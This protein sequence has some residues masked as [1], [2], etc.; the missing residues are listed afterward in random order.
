MIEPMRELS[1]RVAAVVL[2]V[3]IV[4][5]VAVWAY[6]SFVDGQ[7]SVALSTKA[8][9]AFAITTLFMLPGLAVSMAVDAVLLLVRRRVVTRGERGALIALLVASAVTVAT[10]LGEASGVWWLFFVAFASWLPLIGIAITATVVIAVATAKAGRPA[11]TTVP[12]TPA[13]GPTP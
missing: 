1:S 12:S 13:P 8:G 4:V 3:A 7:S 5:C 11:T 9:I 2:I 10:S 6:A